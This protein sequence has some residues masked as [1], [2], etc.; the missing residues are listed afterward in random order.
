MSGYPTLQA[1][2]IVPFGWIYL[3]SAGGQTIYSGQLASEL[4]AQPLSD[5]PRLEIQHLATEVCLSWPATARC[6][7]VEASASISTLSG[8]SPIEETP[9]VENGFCRLRLP[10]TGAARWFRLK[11]EKASALAE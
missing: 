3:A 5:P 11:R 10:A 7:R 8:W 2:N 6:F 4:D 9:T 1:G